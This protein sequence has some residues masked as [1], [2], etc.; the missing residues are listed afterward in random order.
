MDRFSCR[1]AIVTGGGTGI[2]AAA[3]RQLSREGAD[4]VYIRGRGSASRGIGRA[5]AP[6]RAAVD[7]IVCRHG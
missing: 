6:V 4:T 1:V 7:L 5:H 3:A 2:G